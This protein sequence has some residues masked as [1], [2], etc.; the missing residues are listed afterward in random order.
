[1]GEMSATKLITAKAETSL[2]SLIAPNEGFLRFKALVL[3]SW[4]LLHNC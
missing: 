4:V 3:G 1:M 2:Q